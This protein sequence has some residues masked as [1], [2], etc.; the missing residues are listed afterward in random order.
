MLQRRTAPNGVVFYASPLLEQIGVPHAFSTRLGGTSPPPF[1]SLN[2]GNPTGDGTPRDSYPRILS[3][4]P[5]L[6]EAAGCPSGEWCRLHQVHGATV[7]RVRAGEP[8]DKATQGDALVSEDPARAIAVRVA[9]C[10]PIL[11]AS[12]DG[13]TV[14]AVHA[15]WRGVIA[16][17]LRAALQEM[18]AEPAG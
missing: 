14:A 8:L 12:D 17:V 5:L 11:L 3:H 10:A 2:L 9:D 16:G 1:D 7:I 13:R 15:G 4:Y 18:K 6:L